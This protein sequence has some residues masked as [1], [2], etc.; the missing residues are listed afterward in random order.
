MDKVRHQRS[1]LNLYPSAA[2]KKITREEW[3]GHV[4]EIIAAARGRHFIQVKDVY[5]K[6]SSA[7]ALDQAQLLVNEDGV[8][9][10]V[11]SYAKVSTKIARRI[12]EVRHHALRPTEWDSGDKHWIV[13]IAA[14]PGY[15]NSLLFYLRDVT[16]EADNELY[17][18]REKGGDIRPFIFERSNLFGILR[19]RSKT[20]TNTVCR[21]GDTFCHYFREKSQT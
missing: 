15:L 11:Y 12:I 5:S 21:C 18:L 2:L 3:F 9:S 6:V 8:P 1:F 13:F 16:F 17:C 14:K 20:N 19:E 4:F 7:H 10:A